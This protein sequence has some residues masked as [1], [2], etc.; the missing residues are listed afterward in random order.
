MGDRHRF[1]A[2]WHDY[3]GGIYFITIC[4]AG[5]KHIFGHI[6]DGKMY[7]SPLG[8][9]VTSC[10]INIPAH[11]SGVELYNHIVMPNHIHMVIAITT[12]AVTTAAAVGAQYIAPAQQVTPEQQVAPGQ[13]NTT[14]QTNI[15]CL[16]APRHGEPCCDNH[17]NS[18]LAVVIRTFKAA[19]TRLARAQCIA[20][21]PEIWQRN[22]YEHIIRHQTA[23]DNIMNYIDSNPE[24]WGTDCYNQGL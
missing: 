14:G 20:P 19:V 2:D 24:R 10:I 13:Q 1:R 15:G 12:A 4:T 6:A 22:Y 21:L 9:I 16:K 23:F 18:A 5:K 7:L 8:D 11:H 17:Y 3:N